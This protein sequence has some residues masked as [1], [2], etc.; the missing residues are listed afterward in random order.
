MAESAGSSLLNIRN[1]F[2]STTVSGSSFRG[3]DTVN[4]R[5]FVE[6]SK[7]FVETQQKDQQSLSSIQEQIN[8]IQAQINV[9]ST[10]LTQIRSLIEKDTLS[11]QTLL[12]QEQ[13]QERRYTQKRIRIGNENDLERKIETALVA[14]VQ[15]AA[16]K[17]EGIF[18]RI[19]QALTTLF[20]G[21]LTNQG[22]K[23]LKANAEK[24]YDALTD[25]KNNVIRNIALAIGAVASIKLGLTLVTRAITGVVAKIGS[26]ILNTIRAPFAA[27]GAGAARLG[28]MMR[29]N[30][31]PTVAP[32]VSTPAAPKP[33][34]PA[35]KPNIFQRAA[36]AASRA[37]RFL[38]GP[39]IQGTIGTGIDVAMGEKP[40]R[41]VAGA[42]G[43]V[44]AAA[45]GAKVGSIL[46]PIGAL[47]GGIMGYGLGSMFGKGAYNT[48]TGQQEPR[49]VEPKSP[50]IPTPTTKPSETKPTV[51]PTQTNQAS[52]QPFTMIGN[53]EDNVPS[54]Q[55]PKMQ[56]GENNVS[57]QTPMMP[58]AADLTMNINNTQN[59]DWK[60]EEDYWNDITSK[61][62]S[63]ATYEQLGLNQKEIDYL[64]GKTDV[65]PLLAEKKSVQM[66]GKPAEVKTEVGT[67]PIVPPAIK[68]LEQP[69]PNVIVAPLPAPEQ[70][71]RAIPSSTGTDVPFIPSANVDNFYVLY[72]K[73]NYNVV[74]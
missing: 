29:G 64:E 51:T 16:A 17:V 48:V 14:P 26:I 23:A 27:V 35:P 47:V 70:Q 4:K 41:A 40:E 8:N 38:G 20:L 46:G 50:A 73:L 7:K 36:G 60:A 9:L 58:V 22:V 45:A 56:E 42:A 59:I 44:T 37:T 13:E 12:R 39:I 18:G 31:S 6:Q 49:A 10:G 71:K 28:N 2:S 74:I 57:P 67:K 61:L 43:G 15:Q 33:S 30:K 11:E 25:I 21:W 3:E 34:T 24:D 54:I 1:S 66:E 68:P 52:I 5:E 62:Q 19:G 63:G 72:S 69:T 32:G 65:P 53:V 55:P